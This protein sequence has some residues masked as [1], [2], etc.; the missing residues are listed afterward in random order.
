MVKNPPAYTGDTRDMGL[1]P[2]WESSLKGGHGRPLQYSWLE[3]PMDRGTWRTTVHGVAE[4][5]ARASAS[6]HTYAHVCVYMGF[7]GGARGIESACQWKRCRRRGF[8][9]WVGKIPWRRAWQPTPVFLPRIPW[10]EEP[11]GLQPIESQR[12]GHDWSNLA[13]IHAWSV[14]LKI[15]R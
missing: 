11:G 3:N 4:S 12:F 2:G 10:T 13:C 6:A 7:P 1:I 14:L 9:P 5:R 8:D 15:F